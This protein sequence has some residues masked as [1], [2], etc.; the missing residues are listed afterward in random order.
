M[1]TATMRVSTNV[2]RPRDLKEAFNIILAGLDDV[3]VSSC[4]HGHLHVHVRC[5]W[6][7]RSLSVKLSPVKLS[8]FNTEVDTN[9][10]FVFAAEKC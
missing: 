6:L 9:Y 1:S 2:D 8:L 7:Y 3:S 4:I 5:P 10:S